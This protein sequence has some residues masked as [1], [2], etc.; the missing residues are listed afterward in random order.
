MCLKFPFS[1]YR[2]EWIEIAKPD[3]TVCSEPAIGDFYNHEWEQI[4]LCDNR[5]KKLF[6][7]EEA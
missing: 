5:Y 3:C 4:R 2:K 1:L 7:A 6:L